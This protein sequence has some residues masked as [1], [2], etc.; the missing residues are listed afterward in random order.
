M[1]SILLVEETV[2]DEQAIETIRAL[3]AVLGKVRQLKNTVRFL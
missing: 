3:Q 1:S 2:T